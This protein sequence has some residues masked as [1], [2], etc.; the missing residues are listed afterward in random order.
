MDLGSTAM[1]LYIVLLLLALFLVIRARASKGQRRKLAK[2]VVVA[3][4]SIHGGRLGWVHGRWK[5]T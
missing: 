4:S 5:R 1:W 3:N 2:K